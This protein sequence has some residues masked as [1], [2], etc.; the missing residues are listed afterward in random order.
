MASGSTALST[1]VGGAVGCRFRPAA[2]GLH[3]SASFDGA[4][5]E[6][7][8]R[9]CIMPS[10]GRIVFGP[11]WKAGLVDFHQARQRVALG[12]DHA[13]AQLVGEQPSAAVRADT[14][15]FQALQGRDAVGVVRHQVGGP[16]PDAE[17]LLAGVQDRPGRHRRRPAAAVPQS[18]VCAFRHSAAST[19]HGLKPV[20]LKPSGENALTNC[21][22][23]AVVVAREHVL[24]ARRRLSRTLFHVAAS[25][26]LEGIANMLPVPQ[27]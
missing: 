22:V 8:R 16:E 4:V 6:H 15:L 3:V 1:P 18:K 5:D 7:R 12:V 27:R 10:G 23:G 9:G 17:R 14:E 24:E 25:S 2:G 21:Q 13:G 26:R 20:L 11:E 19:F